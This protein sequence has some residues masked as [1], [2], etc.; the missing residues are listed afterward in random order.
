MNKVFLSGIIADSPVLVSK[1]EDANPH[2]VMTLCVSHKTT[3]GLVKRELYTANAWN[4]T[5]LWAHENL[6]Q[7]IR[8]VI[9]G[10]LSQ[11]PLKESAAF[12]SIEVTVEE[13][14]AQTL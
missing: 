14:F 3:Q 4:K 2:M 8:V 11:R 12:P 9:K 6:K 10:Y 1:P 13:F 7:G 5:A